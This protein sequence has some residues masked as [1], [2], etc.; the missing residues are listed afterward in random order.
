MKIALRDF[1]AKRAEEGVFWPNRR[2]IY[3]MIFCN[4]HGFNRCIGRLG[5]KLLIDPE[6]FEKWL[7]EAI[8]KNPE[9]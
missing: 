7:N 9:R 2:D 4:T 3:Q 5:R 1:I 6:L 8:I